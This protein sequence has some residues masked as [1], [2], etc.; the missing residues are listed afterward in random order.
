TEKNL[1]DFRLKHNLQKPGD[2]IRVD[3]WTMRR[4]AEE[5]ASSPRA[6]RGYLA[7]A[8]NF[9]MTGL[10]RILSFVTLA[11]GAGK[12]AAFNPNTDKQGLSYG[13]IQWAQKPKRLHEIVEAFQ[14]AQPELFKSIF[15][16]SADAM[17]THANLPKGGV[18]PATGETVDANFDLI[19]QPWKERFL[20]AALARPLQKIQIEKARAAF[21]AFIA[22]LRTYATMIRSERGY[23]F[24]IDLGN[25]HGTTGAKRIYQAVFAVPVPPANEAEA[26]EKISLESTRRVQLQYPPP[27]GATESREERATRE[28]RDFFRRT[29][30]LSTGDFNQN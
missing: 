6:S 1:K 29:T 13:I 26:L 4:L 9:E 30:L 18:D 16:A 12:F 8:L 27:A 28:R 21:A 24:M 7:L 25:Q 17:V 10:M 15:G 19:R 2:P 14:A 5:T 22:D 23:G 20:N 3:H 11:E